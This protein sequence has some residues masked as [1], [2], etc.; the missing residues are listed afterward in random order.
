[1]GN[2]ITLRFNYNDHCGFLRTSRLHANQ[3]I[4]DG[5]Y[6]IHTHIIYIY[7]AL[8]HYDNF[9]RIHVNVYIQKMYVYIYIHVTYIYIYI[10]KHDTHIL[11]S[12]YIP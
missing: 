10:F 1:M 11:I 6:S 4:N 9:S 8:W 7:M 5:I 12:I 3:R 2:Y